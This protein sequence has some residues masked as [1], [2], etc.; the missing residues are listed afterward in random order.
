MRSPVKTDLSDSA[1]DFQRLVWDAIAPLCGGGEFEAVEGHAN[2]K[3]QEM[4]DLLAGIDGLQILPNR[5]G[6]R[7][8]AS[9]IQWGDQDWGTFTIRETRG[10]GAKTELEKRLYA[11]THPDEGIMLPHLT[12]QAYITQ[13]RTGRLLSAAIAHTKELI[14]YADSVFKAKGKGVWRKPVEQDDGTTNYFLAVRWSEY[15]KAGHYIDIVRPGV[16]QR[17]SAET[18]L[19]MQL[20]EFLDWVEEMRP[21]VED[22]QNGKNKAF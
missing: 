19:G 4:M 16:V 18:V 13:R 3:M 8:I 12:V 9:R 20:D 21:Y 5:M 7:G 1:Y 11:I 15:K 6:I 10:T 2:E 14:P 17:P 22:K